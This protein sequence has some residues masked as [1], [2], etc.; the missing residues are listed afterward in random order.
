MVHPGFPVHAHHAEIQRVRCGK[1]AQAKQRHRDRNAGALGK[2]AHL[3]HG[4]RNDDA[5][6]A[7]NQRPLRIVDQLQRLLI[8]R[9]S[10]RKIGPVA[11]QLRLGR[12]PVEL[13]R[14]LLRIFGDIDQHRTRT[15]RPRH[16]KSFADRARH[17]A[18]VRHQI[19]VLGDRKS[20]A[21]DVGF[22]K[23]VRPDQLAAHL[24]GD[25]DDRYGIE[26]GGGDSGDHVGRAR[27]RGCDRNSHLVRWRARSR[28]PCG[29]RPVRGAPARDGSCCASARHR[30][31]EW[32]RPDS[33]R[34]CFT[35]SRSRHSQRML[36][37]VMVF[38]S[39][40]VSVFVLPVVGVLLACSSIRHATSL[41]VRGSNA[42]SVRIRVS[43]Q[44][45]R[46][47]SSKSDVPSGAGQRSDAPLAAR[48]LPKKQNPPC[49]RFWRVGFGS[50]Y[51]F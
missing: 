3:A 1:R 45:Y 27:P 20:H 43:L 40:F 16:I 46:V 38:D 28:R 37:P 29:S 19:V 39:V 17:F 49:Q 50:T 13:A 21:R 15:S 11:R 8:L 30:P 26:H 32:R 42:V 33:Q 25:A 14:A 18:G 47:R 48:P 22:L 34:R 31:A 24:P 23:R 12:F 41:P 44:R 7:E 36:A 10:G 4:S 35:P 5:V 51:D 9:R 2:I 6:P